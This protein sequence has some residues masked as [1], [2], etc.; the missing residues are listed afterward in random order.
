MYS[1]K[2]FELGQRCR[3]RAKGEY[4]GKVVGFGQS[5]C[6]RESGCFGLNWLYTGKSGCNRAKMIAGHGPL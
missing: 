6:I 4:L 2:V 3:I 5:V 1:A